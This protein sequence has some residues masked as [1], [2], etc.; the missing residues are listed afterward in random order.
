MSKEKK[1][2]GAG[3]GVMVVKDNKVFPPS[4]YVLDRY[5]DGNFYK[6]ND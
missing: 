4:Q 3:F 1:K 5:L 6:K 2:V